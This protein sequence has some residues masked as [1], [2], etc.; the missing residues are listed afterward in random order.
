MQMRIVRIPVISP[1]HE[2]KEDI[3]DQ[4]IFFRKARHSLNIFFTIVII[5]KQNIIYVYII[6]FLLKEI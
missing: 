2:G 4:L 1:E 6:Q 3:V 5:I